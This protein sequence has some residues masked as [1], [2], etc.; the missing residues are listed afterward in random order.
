MTQQQ[1]AY[2]NGKICY[3]EIPADNV[4]SASSFYHAVFG[5]KIRTRDDG[6]VAFDD[7]VNQVSGTWVRNKAPQTESGLLVY[8]MVDSVATTAALIVTHGG[9][10]IRTEELGKGREIIARF[11]DPYGNV[12]GI[13]QH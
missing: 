9:S 4:I 12:F 8:I 13:F 10:I 11:K 6:S 5:W 1:P 2:G 7:G 3:I